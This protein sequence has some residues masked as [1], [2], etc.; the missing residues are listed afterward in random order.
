MKKYLLFM[1]LIPGGLTLLSFIPPFNAS[2][3]PGLPGIG[4]VFMIWLA[5]GVVCIFPFAVLREAAG[6]IA[7]MFKNRKGKKEPPQD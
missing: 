7:D 1:I 2:P 6:M 3:G 5:L 4:A